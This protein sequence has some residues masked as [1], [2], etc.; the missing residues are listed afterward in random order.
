MK[1]IQPLIYS[2]AMMITLTACIS[3]EPAVYVPTVSNPP[4]LEQALKTCKSEASME[5]R[6]AKRAARAA[7]GPYR[8]TGGGF[9]AGLAYGMRGTG[10]GAAAYSDYL[11]LC[12]KMMGYRKE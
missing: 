12:M 8:S 11:Y 2:G 7:A 10:S 9:A 5:A 6:R 4:N 1:R 3:R